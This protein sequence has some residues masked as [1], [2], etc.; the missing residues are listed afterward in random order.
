MTLS[1]YVVSVSKLTGQTWR[2]QALS[3]QTA[4]PAMEMV[5]LRTLQAC[6]AFLGPD[7]SSVVIPDGCKKV[8]PH[9]VAVT[10]WLA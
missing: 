2:S 1:V 7:S 8:H 6:A 3:S 9:K 4:L 10:L 5:A